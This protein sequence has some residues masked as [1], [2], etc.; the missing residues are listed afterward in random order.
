[1]IRFADKKLLLLFIQIT[2]TALQ[3]EKKNEDIKI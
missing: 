1:M 3:I 2:V